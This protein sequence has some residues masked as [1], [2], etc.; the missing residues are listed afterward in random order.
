M[1][2]F[3]KTG[4]YP[5]FKKRGHRQSAEYTR[6]AFKFS[7]PDPS[8]PNLVVA[9]LGRL[10][11]R[12]S[13]KFTSSPSTV[14]I[15]K[16]PSGK[17]FV[18]LV[19]DEYFSKLEPTAKTVGVDLGIKAIAVFSDGT[20]V[21][22]PK[23]TGKNQA[24]LC[25]AQRLLS[26]KVKGSGRWR[27][28][29]AKVARIHERIGNCRKDHLDKVTTDIVRSFDHIMIEDLNV[30]GVVRNRRLAKSLSD[31]SFGMIRL[32]LEYKCA[33]YGRE[34]GLVGRF[35]PSSKTCSGCGLVV[36]KLPLSVREWVCAGCGSRHDRDLNAA[37]NIL[38]EG[39]SVAARGGLV[40]RPAAPFGAAGRKGLR[41]VNR[42]ME[43]AC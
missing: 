14:T 34:L 10:K 22:N 23:H 35:Y 21:L 6:S 24:R 15:V 43:S 32:M 7:S 13:R 16:Q 42:S 12:W 29:R 17:Y 4:K 28:Q 38:A 26:R 2:F 40:R 30:K 18:S 25:K 39:H 27:R 19:L 3:R 37:K 5:T 36:G 1:N 20:Q 33:R 31:V 41:N 11:V 8:D 9:G